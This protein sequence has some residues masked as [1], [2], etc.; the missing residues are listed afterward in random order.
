MTTSLTRGLL[1]IVLLLA[2]IPPASAHTISLSYSEISIE[3][4]QVRWLLRM[5]EPELD[6][7][8]GLDKNHDGVVDA[9]E[10][11]AGRTVLVTYVESHVKLFQ[12]SR[13][14][15]ATIGEPQLWKDSQGNEFVQFNLIFTTSAGSM[16][17]LRLH[18][19]LLRDVVAGHQTLAKI[20]AAGRM[21]D[22]VFAN[23]QDYLREGSQ[24]LS[25]FAAFLQ[26]VHMGVMHI[27]T[28]YDH[29]AFLLGVVLIGGSF[30][31][32]VKVVTSFT[33]AHSI[34]L[35]LAALSIVV[36]PS[37]IVESGIALSIMYI[38]AENL[39]FKQF[40]RRWIVTFF[41]GLVHGFGFASV[42]Q[43][44][45]LAGR[46]LATALFSFNLGVEI[47]QVCIVSL[48]LPLLWYMQKQWYNPWVIRVAST[49]IFVLGSFW[50][51]QR[52]S[53]A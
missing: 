43:E 4:H 24:G 35:A 11:V 22:F 8:F 47:G 52:V 3:E 41:F 5:P 27:F 42:L 40:D 10:L 44:L 25:A 28:G 34:T 14:L 36:L 7:L 9:S 46:L 13:E 33:V 45:H 48:L 20:T 12:D 50:F 29:I 6:L 17:H 26:F 18:C 2:A 39:F 49:G 51:W 38:A 53:G 32:I 21:E 23:G 19:D 31:T 1:P 37:R 15:P 16:D 30:K